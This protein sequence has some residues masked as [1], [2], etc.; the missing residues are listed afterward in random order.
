MTQTAPRRRVASVHRH[1]TGW[2]A[3]L[4]QQLSDRLFADT[5]ASAREHGWRITETAGRF[6]FGARSYCDPR[7]SQHGVA[8]AE[9]RMH[10]EEGR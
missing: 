10:R 3:R 4:Q 6:G 9:P 1:L 7:F 5:D 2:L 8:R